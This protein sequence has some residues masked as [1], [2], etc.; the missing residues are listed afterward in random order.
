MLMISTSAAKRVNNPPMRSSEA[1]TSAEIAKGDA[2]R[3]TNAQRIGENPA[4]PS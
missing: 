3:V 4:R 1:K 2:G